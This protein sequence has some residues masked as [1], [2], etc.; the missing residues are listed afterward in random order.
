MNLSAR[1]L[2]L[3]LLL[4]A[5]VAAQ[6]A[7][8]ILAPMPLPP[9]SVVPVSAEGPA[10][11]AVPAAAPAT[12]AAALPAAEA[13]RLRDLLRDDARRADLLRTLDALSTASGAPAAAPAAGGDP[14]TPGTAP[15]AE[16]AASPIPEILAPN[17]LGAQLLMGASQRI[18]SMSDQLVA[19][20]Q[21]LTDLPS[22]AAFVSNLARDPVTQ[23]RVLD[24]SWKLALLFGLGLL[25]ESMA[26]RSISRWRDRLD[27]ATPPGDAPWPWL[28]RVPLVLGRLVLDMIPVGAFAVVSYGLIGAVNPLPTTQLILLGCNNAYILARAILI[29]ARML[30]SPASTHLRLLPCTDETAAYITVWLRRIVAVGVVGFSLAETGLLFGLPWSAYDSIIRLVLLMISLFLGIVVLQNRAAVAA[31]LRAPPLAEG[32]SPDRGRRLLRALRSRLAEVWHVIAILYLLALWGVWAL[33]VRDGFERLLH[34]SLTTVA[35]VAVAKL[36]DEGLRRALIRGFRV[37]DDLAVRYP[38]LELR[39]NRYLPVLKGVLST[40]IMV[41]AVLVLLESWG[42]QSFAW[43]KRGALGNRLL[44]S[45][46]QMGFVL[47]LAVGVWEAVN[48]SI[49]RYLE[50]L[51]RDAKAAKSARVRTLLPMLKTALL[52]VILTFVILNVLTEIGVNVAPLIAG[53]G[54]IG[55]AV[56]FGSQKLVQDVITG[57][58][59]LFEDAVAV[60]DSVQLGGMSGTVEQL[61]IR[62]IRLR[63]L[64]GSIHIVPFSAV[65]TVTNQSRDFGFAVMD[66]A[67]PYSE[68]TDRV[69]EVLR[70]VGESMRDDAKYGPMIRDS[71]DVMGVDKL[72]DTSVVLR[73]RLKTDPS[74]RW[75]VGREF[76]RRMKKLFAQEGIEHPSQAPTMLV[77]QKPKPSA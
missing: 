62:S 12:P 16:P 15:A 66:V 21:A 33:E 32:E 38:G 75:A 65:T 77:E 55:L 46:V 58:F 22:M 52:V 61:S 17:T 48:A 35:V 3:F 71:L 19:A 13:A 9:A 69:A 73:V 67:L 8:P 20:I 70:C 42:I 64:D 5:P 44:G 49:A 43:F 30:F 11:A 14:A 39:A 50:R 68:D 6:E 26:R 28:R 31:V 57:I 1:L 76:N 53:A 27:A 56:G 34:V 4:A 25:S 23:A 41:V 72:G 37:G 2:L 36:L 74:A 54:V 29:V 10:P 40:L 63:A 18:Q 59:L 24:A 47:L 51:S 45:V 7:P 60:G